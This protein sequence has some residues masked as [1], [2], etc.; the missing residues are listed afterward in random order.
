ML[1]VLLLY[2]TAVT[3]RACRHSTCLHGNN[4]QAPYR[5]GRVP[6]VWKPTQLNPKFLG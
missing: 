2:T 4:E 5:V 6:F 3:C 1:L